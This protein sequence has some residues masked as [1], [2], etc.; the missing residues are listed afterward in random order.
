MKSPNNVLHSTFLAS[1]RPHVR[2]TVGRVV[3]YGNSQHWGRR[4]AFSDLRLENPLSIGANYIGNVK[5]DINVFADVERLFERIQSGIRDGVIVLVTPLRRL[6]G[7]YSIPSYRNYSETL[8]R[9]SAESVAYVEV[10]LVFFENVPGGTLK[11]ISSTGQIAVRLAAML[12]DVRSVDFVGISLEA[13]VLTGSISR[14]IVDYSKILDDCQSLGFYFELAEKYSLAVGSDDNQRS[15]N[16]AIEANLSYVFPGHEILLSHS[17]FDAVEGAAT[18][19]S[20]HRVDLINRFPNVLYLDSDVICA[21]N[22]KYF[23]DFFFEYAPDGIFCS[24]REQYLPNLG[25]ILKKG[26]TTVSLSGYPAVV[27]RSTQSLS[28]RFN[29]LDKQSKDSLFIHF[30]RIPSQPWNFPLH[31][32]YRLWSYWRY[33]DRGGSANVEDRGFWPRRSFNWG[34]YVHRLENSMS[35]LAENPRNIFLAFPVHL[36][37]R[38]SLESVL[39]RL[40]WR[41]RLLVNRF[42]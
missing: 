21:I 29:S 41:V 32:L 5:L 15:V 16:T 24:L 18:K 36:V 19:F 37:R 7:E 42:L 11:T 30:T 6:I 33:F 23:I 14:A 22:A 38:F 25:V 31:H 1:L 12:T 26:P 13:K 8:A 2:G 3:V 17:M 39:L 20:D 28:S 4:G 35:A 27:A 34:D 40:E 9:L 10:P